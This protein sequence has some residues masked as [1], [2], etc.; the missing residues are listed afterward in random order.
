MEASERGWQARSVG[1]SST[2][3]ARS[4]RGMGGLQGLPPPLPPPRPTFQRQ[5]RFLRLLTN[6]WSQVTDCWSQVVTAEPVSKRL[7]KPKAAFAAAA[8][9]AAAAEGGVRPRAR[10]RASPAAALRALSS[11]AVEW[12]RERALV[13][14]RRGTL[15]ALSKVPEF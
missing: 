6:C 12:K 8:A 3:I 15:L 10:G 4:A 2:V 13:R 11:N 5:P 7:K 9:T 14:R 1:R